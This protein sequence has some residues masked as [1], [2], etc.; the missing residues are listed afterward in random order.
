MTPGQVSS[1]ELLR[2]IFVLVM[3]GSR[4][5]YQAQS[6]GEALEFVALDSHVVAS[7]S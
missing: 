6:Q 3:L 7:Y 1:D 4:T 5:F 2:S